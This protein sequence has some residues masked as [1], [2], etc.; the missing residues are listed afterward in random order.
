[1]NERLKLTHVTGRHA[2][3]A[4]ER[5]REK[6]E[7]HD[8]QTTSHPVFVERIIMFKAAL[9]PS[10]SR[11]LSP[12][13]FLTQ[14]CRSK[15]T[16][17]SLP[18]AYDALEPA[19]SEQIMRLHHTKHHQTYVTNLNAAEEKLAAAA[20]SGDVKAAIALQNAIRFNGGGHLNR[21]F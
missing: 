19:I 17:P 5:R 1:M 11:V 9:K 10:S 21:T 7:W 6:I 15:H 4:L 18:Y 14:A 8:R 20:S 2:Q 3:R 12:S 13:S 16:L